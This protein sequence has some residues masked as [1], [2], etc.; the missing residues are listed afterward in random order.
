MDEFS[1]RVS[2]RKFSK[3]AASAPAL[4]LGRVAHAQTQ[5]REALI[6]AA[7]KEGRVIVYSAYVS[8]LTHEPIAKAFERKYGVKV[9]TFMARGPELRERMRV[10]QM[11]GRFLA[12]VQHNASSTT[13]IMADADKIVEP[14]GGLSGAARLKPEYAARADTLQVPI[15][16]IN[17]GILVNT[18]VVKPGDE[19]KGW[20]DLL[21][22]KWK[23]KLL[24]DDPRTTGGGRVWFHMTTDKFGRAYHDAL[25]KQEPTFSRDYG[26]AVRRVTR[27]EFSIYVP[28]IF[29]QAAPLKGL[30][31]KYVV[32]AE[33]VTYGSYCVSILRNPPHPNAARLLADFYLGDEA[34][35]VYANT[36][37][38]IVIGDLKT[39][40]SAEMQ[41]LANVKPLVEED[42]TRID[43]YLAL[44]KDIYK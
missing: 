30:P 9:E 3:W 41:P 20:R 36:G 8:P 27:G 37:H 43:Q 16:T 15:F 17:Y 10:E 1:G 23:G 13:K 22:P 12:D 40:I 2:R 21:D 26:E 33:G 7:K 29:S 34:Q 39:P 4:I 18:A 11:T 19:P 42:F 38:G 31:V 6:E 5:G 35:G 44:A 28:L 14:H 24:I 25:A 32:P